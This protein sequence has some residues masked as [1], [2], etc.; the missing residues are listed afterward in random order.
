[1]GYKDINEL[2]MVYTQRGFL[3]RAYDEHD[4]LKYVQDKLK[5]DDTTLKSNDSSLEFSKQMTKQFT[6][7]DVYKDGKIIFLKN[8]QFNQ[9]SCGPAN[10]SLYDINF[11][12]NT[13]KPT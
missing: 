6:N 10:S 2:H 13:T 1:M 9:S 4:S 11:C 7:N 12:L 8:H 3:C 5:H